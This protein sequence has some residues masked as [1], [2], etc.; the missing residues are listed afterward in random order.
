[1]S[2]LPKMFVLLTAALLSAAAAYWFLDLM[3]YYVSERRWP[4]WGAIIVLT[5]GWFVLLLWI[6]AFRRFAAPVTM[7]LR[8]ALCLAVTLALAAAGLFVVV[9]GILRGET[10]VV[11][12]TSG[13]VARQVNWA[14]TPVDFTLNLFLWTMLTLLALRAFLTMVRVAVHKSVGSNRFT[15]EYLWPFVFET[16]E[17]PFVD[18]QKLPRAGGA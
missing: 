1:M 5:I 9:V 18:L 8:I 4:G 17:F 6:P 10:G 16:K 12:R 13:T 7:T 2:Q 3:A 15:E 14:N 11:V